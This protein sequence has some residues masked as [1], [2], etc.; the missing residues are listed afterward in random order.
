M[1]QPD[2]TAI[3]CVPSIMNDDGWPDDA[4]LRLVC[5]STSPVV[6]SK[7]RNMRSLVPPLKTSPPP[8]A[9]TGPQFVEFAK[10][11][12]QTRAPVSTFHA[13]TSPMC[14]APGAIISVFDAPV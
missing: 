3:C 1:P 12:V 7:A 14:C 8:V 5:H 13:C 6:A 2:C 9:S 11:C 10:V 4:R